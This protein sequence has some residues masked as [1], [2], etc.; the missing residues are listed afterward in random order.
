VKYDSLCGFLFIGWSLHYIPFFIMGRQLFLH[1]YLPALYFAILLSCCIFDLVSSSLR[2]RLRLQ[3]A[4][5]FIILAIW[6]FQYF[7]PLAYGNPWTKQKCQKAKWLKTWDFSCNDFLDNYSQYTGIA[8]ATPQRS[9]PAVATIG[10]EPGGRPP[11]VVADQVPGKSIEKEQTTVAFGKAEPGVDIFA[12]EPVKD[13]KSPHAAPSLPADE[14]EISLAFS[15]AS[16]DPLINKEGKKGEEERTNK[17]D[18]LA[19][20]QAGAKEADLSIQTHPTMKD[21][22]QSYKQQGPLDE[23]AAEADRAAKELYPDARDEK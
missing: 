16:T 14:K 22:G 10:G 4:V 9:E 1:H 2:P 18:S 12:A 3:I 15:Q 6:N 7:S 23:P 21:G 11:I 20:S 17:T 19:A 13:I 8:P 5:F